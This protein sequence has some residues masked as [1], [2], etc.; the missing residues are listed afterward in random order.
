M[1]KTNY[2]TH[3]KRCMHA[4][5][6]D[7][8]YVVSAIKNGYKELGFSDHTPW[9]YG[10]NYVAHMRMKLAQFDDYYASIASLR[11]KYKDQISIKIGLECEYFPKYMPW[12]KNFIKEKSIDYIIFGNHYYKTDERQVY[13]GTA[14]ESEEMMRYYVDEAIEGMETGLYSYLCHPDLFMRGHRVFDDI[15]KRESRRL[16]EAAKRLNIPLEYNLAGAQYNDI[17]NTMQY[18]HTEF[19]K[20][21]AEVGNTA[22]IGVDA[23]EPAALEHD[24]YRNQALALFEELHMNVTDTIKF[25]DSSNK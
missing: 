22:I 1:R 12:L 10:S 11:E 21:A 24:K 15:A 17:M 6:A 7:E 23:H 4:S 2:H 5:G 8:E 14:C 19:W 9:K 13:F 20:I 18:P 3:T 16:C 25:F